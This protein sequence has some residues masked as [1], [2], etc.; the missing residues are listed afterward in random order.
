[1]MVKK[2]VLL[3]LLGLTG[4]I[5][6]DKE[7]VI[8]ADLKTTPPTSHPKPAH[9]WYAD[10]QIGHGWTRNAG[11]GNPD[12]SF[13]DNATEGYDSDLGHSGFTGVVIGRQ[14]CRWSALEFEYNL[15]QTMGYQ[16]YQTT[17]TT[18][19][20][21]G[22]TGTKRMRFFNVDHQSALVNVKL[23]APKDWALN[24]RG[25][26]VAPTLGA[27]LGLGINT[28]SNF[29]TVGYNQVEDVAISTDGSTISSTTTL[30]LG[31]TTSVALPHTKI[32]LAWQANLGLV[33]QPEKSETT[34]SVL[35]RYYEG[36]KFASAGKFMLNTAD[37]G[38]AQVT[39]AA[40]TGKLKMHQLVVKV[41]CPF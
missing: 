9:K 26:K 27:G 32:G 31:T 29:H 36:G 7:L 4:A 21:A 20:T 35:Y 14:M 33:F 3:S 1:M 23:L 16:K 5:Q 39:G 2:L 8:K 28:V 37:Q 11:V 6:A 34:F 12:T 13:W 40:W 24:V 38:G 10:S 22:F 18:G 17:T 30:A 41:E 15:F 25:F 19:S